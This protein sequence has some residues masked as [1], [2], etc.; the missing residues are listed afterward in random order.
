M[1]P[2]HLIFRNINLIIYYKHIG[3]LLKMSGGHTVISTPIWLSHI[4]LNVILVPYYT[5]MRHGMTLT[6]NIAYAY[7]LFRNIFCRIV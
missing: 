6:S 3:T 2:A 4:T 1:A 5:N 7:S